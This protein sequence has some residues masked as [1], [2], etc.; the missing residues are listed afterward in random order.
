MG[1]RCTTPASAP[2]GR[3][4][5][6]GRRI[7]LDLVYVLVTVAFF[8]AAVADVAACRS[9]DPHIS[10]ANARLQAPRVARE[11]GLPLPEVLRLV[12]RV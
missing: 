9:V 1:R 7:V 12:Q 4:W 2:A 5:S 3:P 11:R 6:H 8:A 10:V